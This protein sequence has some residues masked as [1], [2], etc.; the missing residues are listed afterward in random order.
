M[1]DQDKLQSAEL[2]NEASIKLQQ[3][4]NEAVI[5]KESDQKAVSKAIFKDLKIF[6][7]NR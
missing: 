7:S 2:W 1:P 4:I 5:T 6:H 3:I